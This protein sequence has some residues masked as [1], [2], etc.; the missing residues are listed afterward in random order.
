VLAEHYE[1][2]GFTAPISCMVVDKFG[3][4]AR[5]SIEAEKQRATGH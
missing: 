1:P 3:K 5:I 4:A 2:E